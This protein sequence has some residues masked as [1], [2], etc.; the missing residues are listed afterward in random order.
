M[1]TLA[2]EVKAKLAAEKAPKTAPVAKPKTVPSVHRLTNGAG[3]K[4]LRAY[5][6][7]ALHMGGVITK[8]GLPTKNGG[9][10]DWLVANCT[11]AKRAIGYHA[12]KG[13]LT[14]KGGVV[15]L[16]GKSKL[17][18]QFAAEVKDLADLI[19]AYTALMKSGTVSDKIGATGGSK[20]YVVA[21]K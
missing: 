19:E 21:P 8:T 5:W 16:V 17:A 3:G 15:K 7:A 9:K 12:D 20:P 10:E 13:N 6:I 2:T 18:T 1:Q 11:P 14:V 4:Q